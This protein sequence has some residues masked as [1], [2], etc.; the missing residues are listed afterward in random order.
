MNN[1]LAFKMLIHIFTIVS[2]VG[3]DVKRVRHT[4]NYGKGF[5]GYQRDIDNTR[6][7]QTYIYVSM[8][9]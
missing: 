9:G 8:T 5:W 2:V 7:I 3:R 6:F 1:W 4:T